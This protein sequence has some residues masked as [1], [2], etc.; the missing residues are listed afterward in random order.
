[1]YMTDDFGG[2]SPSSDWGLLINAGGGIDYEIDRGITIGTSVIFNLLP[3]DVLS[4][5]S[6]Y[7]WQ[8]I[9]VTFAL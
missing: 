9:T 1:M 7:T 8:M 6:F 3:V 5:N 2:T 4:Q